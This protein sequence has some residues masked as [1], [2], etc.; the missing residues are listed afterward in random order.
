MQ[1]SSGKTD[2]GRRNAGGARSLEVQGCGSESVVI[3]QL[4]PCEHFE[5]GVVGEVRARQGADARAANDADVLQA[6]QPA[7][8]NDAPAASQ[9]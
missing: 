3:A 1:L 6:G 7:Q 2:H 5:A 9:S 8:R 4:D